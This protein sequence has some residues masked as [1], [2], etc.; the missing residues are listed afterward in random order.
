MPHSPFAAELRDAVTPRAVLMMAGVLPVQPVFVLSR[1]V[2]L[3]GV[4]ERGGLSS[5][6]L[7]V[8]WLVAGCV[9]AAMLGVTAGARPVSRHRAVVRLAALLPYAVLSGLGGALVVGPAL[10]V[11]TGHFLRL[12]GLGA[13]VVFTAGAV[14]IGLQASCGVLGVGFAAVV[15][16]VPGAPG[17]GELPLGGAAPPSW[18]EAGCW[19]PTGA[20]VSA[21]RDVVLVGGHA[22]TWPLGVLGVWAA[23]GVVLSLLFA[24]EP[25][26][27]V[28][29]LSSGY[30]GPRDL[31]F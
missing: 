4:G 17:P 15:F 7:V 27:R 2:S 21:V 16:V 28:P 30:G 29:A 26:T 8:G 10:G 11:L 14:T 5:F 12:W 23:A 13:L 20:G 19:L 22:V 31:R 3:A 9:A 18:R 6:P 24:R 25:D 1:V